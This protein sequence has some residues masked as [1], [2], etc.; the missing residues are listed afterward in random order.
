MYNS[1]TTLKPFREVY[2]P[3]MNAKHDL[4]TIQALRERVRE[5]EGQL[6]LADKEIERLEKVQF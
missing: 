3:E 5:L 4:A 1:V 2:H 6:M